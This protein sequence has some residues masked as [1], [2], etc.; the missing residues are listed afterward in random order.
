[1]V[2][3]TLTSAIVLSGGNVVA[4][5]TRTNSYNATYSNSGGILESISL[6]YGEFSL[7]VLCVMCIYKVPTLYTFTPACT[8]M[9]HIFHV[10]TVLGEDQ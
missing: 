9:F 7:E 8:M 5:G 10:H 2:K 4:D 3:S 6:S 1:M